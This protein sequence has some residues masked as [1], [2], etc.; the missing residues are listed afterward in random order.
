[1]FYAIYRQLAL[2]LVPIY[3]IIKLGLML[4]LLLSNL[5]NND[6]TIYHVRTK[7]KGFLL[8]CHP[9]PQG[10]DGAGQLEVSLDDELEY[11]EDDEEEDVDGLDED[12]SVSAVGRLCSGTTLKQT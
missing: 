6:K 3:F 5:C 10:N 7:P 1:M 9:S 2:V 8:H 12:D 4:H 11:E